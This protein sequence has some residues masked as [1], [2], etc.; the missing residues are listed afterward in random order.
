MKIEVH[1]K[2]V[3]TIT[4]EVWIF[5]LIILIVAILASLFTVRLLKTKK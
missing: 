3:Y 4:L 1:N 2:F 5:I